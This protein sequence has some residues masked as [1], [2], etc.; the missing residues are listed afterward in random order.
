M[1]YAEKKD[2]TRLDQADEKINLKMTKFIARVDVQ[3][4]FRKLEKELWEELALKLEKKTFDRKIEGF[5][6]ERETALKSLGKE[7]ATLREVLTRLRTKQDDF[8]GSIN[9]LKDDLDEKM[10]G[11]EGKKLWSNFRT[12]AKYDEL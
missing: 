7:I 6:A 5:E 2:I 1:D 11:K 4:K 12:Y 3:E 9:V 8:S 10:S